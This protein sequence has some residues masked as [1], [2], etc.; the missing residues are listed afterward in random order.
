MLVG[1]RMDREVEVHAEMCERFKEDPWLSEVV[2]A[3]TDGNLGD[4]RT[5]RRAKHCT[6]NF[7]IEDSKLWC[8]RT[9]GKDR[10]ARVEC[11]P[12]AEGRQLAS[13]THAENGHFGWDQTKLRLHNNWFWPGMDR[14][15]REAITGCAQCK[16]FGLRHTNALLQPIKRHQPFDLVSADYLTLPKG[17][18]GYMTVLLIMDTFS[19][20]VWAYRLKPAGTGKTTLDGLRNL[21]FHYQKPDTLMT[22]GGLHFDN[23]E[24]GAYCKAQDIRHITMLA[25]T[26]WTNG[27]VENANKIL[28]GRLKR[29]CALNLDADTGCNPKPEKWPNYLEE[30]I[31]TMNDW[32]IPAVGFMPRELLWGRREM[33][34]Q[35]DNM[36]IPERTDSDVEHHF[37]FSD[38]LHSQ[39]YV[40]VLTEAAY[41]KRQFNRKVH[42]VTFTVGDQ[43]QVYDSK[44]DMTFDAR[45]KLLPRWSPPQTIAERHLNSYKLHMPQGGELPGTFHACRLHHY[46]PQRDEWPGHTHRSKAAQP[47]MEEE[48]EEPGKTLQRL[49]KGKT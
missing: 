48:D 42:P 16:N 26:P 41:R 27:L 30:A 28:L 34:M 33:G 32:I 43:V 19:T 31:Q 7:M 13:Q 20:F 29:M 37:I 4:I 39:G 47:L 12:R 22:D 46:I 9:K 18:G 10:T 40:E 15:T 6:L 5:R 24:V 44:L 8:V 23:E 21:S 35:E 38:L 2:E 17:K 3:L 45:A 11:I 14:D 25:Y 1:D 36:G 49:F